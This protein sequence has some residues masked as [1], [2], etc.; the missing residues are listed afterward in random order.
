MNMNKFTYIGLIL[1]F[2]YIGLFTNI[3]GINENDTN[4]YNTK[5]NNKNKIPNQLTAHKAKALVITC[6]NFRLIDDAVYYLNKI[7]YTNNYDEFILAGA[8]LGYN[9]TKYSAWT[10][11]LDTHIGLAKKLHDIKE[12]IVIDHMSCGAYKI[13]YNKESITEQDEIELH[14]QN[15][16]T[17]KQTINK[18]YPEL[19]V[20][21]LLMKLDGSVTEY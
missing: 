6:M 1:F 20:T 9:Q 12:I 16:I 4:E 10:E 21:T 11:T 3:L 13:F 17:F 2:I 18:K 14:K 19:T 7:G 8:S 5:V 15:F